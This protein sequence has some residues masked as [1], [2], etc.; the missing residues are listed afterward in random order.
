MEI[1]EIGAEIDAIARDGALDLPAHLGERE[2]ALHL[3]SF[4]ADLLDEASLP[5]DVA[6]DLRARIDAQRARIDAATRRLVA[7]VRAGIQA[8]RLGPAALRA[9]CNRY[10][11]YRPDSPG[12]LHLDYE[13]LDILVGGLFR[14]DEPVEETVRREQGMVHL[15][16]SPASVV[17]EMADRLAPGPDDLLVD[18][19]AGLGHVAMLY[20]LLTGAR[21]RGIEVQPTYTERARRTA[22]AL[23]L[24]GVD[25][26]TVD[27]RRAAYDEGSAYYM[28]T[29]FH[30]RI[31]RSVLDR[32]RAAATERPV[33]ER[34]RICTYGP[35]T[36]VVAREAWLRSL[37]VP[38]GHPSRLAIF[39]P[40]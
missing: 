32:L 3:L 4:L 26:V 21:A 40:R 19:G 27:V 5:R 12:H 14:L 17:L 18:L 30:G 13:P 16:F 6:T 28:F 36:L 24:G 35:C 39:S 22:A 8:A 15:E 33:A 25:F 1:D 38:A 7:E 9:L 34:L 31:L 29:P 10:T 37:D 11:A 20:H 23:G 2:E